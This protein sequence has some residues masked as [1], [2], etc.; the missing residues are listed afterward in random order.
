MRECSVENIRKSL[1]AYRLKDPKDGIW[2]AIRLG[3]SYRP[4]TAVV[5]QGQLQ[6]NGNPAD[7]YYDTRFSLSEANTGNPQYQ[8][9]RN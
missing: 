7:E 1:S 6:N 5:Y 4:G 9:C 8:R 3:N 2:Q